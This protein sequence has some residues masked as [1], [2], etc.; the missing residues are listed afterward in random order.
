VY[1]RCKGCHTVHPVNARLLAQGK[2]RFRCGKCKISG[3]ALESLFDEW[4]AAGTR[5]PAS[6]QMPVLGLPIDLQEAEKSRLNPEQSSKPGDST[7]EPSQSGRSGKIWL[8]AAWITA[9]IA[10]TIVTTFKLAEFY[11]QPLLE[12]P[13]V[14]TAIIRLGIKDAPAKQPYRDVNQIHLVSRELRT[15]PSRSG[16]LQLTATIVNRAPQ[17]QPYPELEVIL[18]DATGQPISETRFTPAD[19]LAEDAT[20]DSGMTPQAYL[21]LVLELPDPGNEAVGFELNFL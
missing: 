11:E 16:V 6:G 15:H 5:P 2:G 10:L 7:E 17:A 4:P 9:A 3:N 20:G 18:L 21:P 13:A 8:R 19:Y 1:T 14:Q 12:Q